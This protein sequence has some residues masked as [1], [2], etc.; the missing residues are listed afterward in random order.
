M[1]YDDED[2]NH[3]SVYSGGHRITRRE[4]RAYASLLN[5]EIGELREELSGEYDRIQEELE[6][7][8]DRR[9]NCWTRR[10][11]SWGKVRTLTP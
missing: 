8:R 3:D 10:D 11:R 2:R 7:Y 4:A 5:E 6:D 9:M 1:T